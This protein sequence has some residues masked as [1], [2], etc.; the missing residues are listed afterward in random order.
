MTD[1]FHCLSIPETF[2]RFKHDQSRLREI[3]KRLEGNVTAREIELIFEEVID[4][5][6]ELC[7]GTFQILHRLYR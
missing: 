3:R 2:S 4:T 1:N 5:A 6:D 7:S